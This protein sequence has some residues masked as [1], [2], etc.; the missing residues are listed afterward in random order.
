MRSALVQVQ[1]SHAVRLL[2]NVCDFRCVHFPFVDVHVADSPPVLVFRA[3][4]PV[5][6]TVLRLAPF[7][8]QIDGDYLGPPLVISRYARYPP[9]AAGVPPFLRMHKSADK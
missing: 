6:Q 1:L 2:K 4:Q 7:A 5:E 3:S 9:S 8:E